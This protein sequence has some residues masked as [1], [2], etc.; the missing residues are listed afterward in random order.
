MFLVQGTIDVGML[1]LINIDFIL[2]LGMNCAI[3]SLHQPL[4]GI[5]EMVISL[6]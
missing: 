5:G 6:M 3:V 4:G 1:F 2:L